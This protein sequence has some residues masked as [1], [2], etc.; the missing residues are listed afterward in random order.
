MGKMIKL[1]CKRVRFYSRGDEDA[2]FEWTSKIKVIKKFEGV[3]DE[4][5]LYINSSRISDKGFRELTALFQRYKVDKRQLGQFINSKNI[6]KKLSQPGSHYNVYP[7]IKTN[8]K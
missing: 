3:G 1:V 5:L 7:K 6:Q 4:M 8:T 2:F